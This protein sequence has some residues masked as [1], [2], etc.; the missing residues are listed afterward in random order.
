[1][2]ISVSPTGP[3]GLPFPR[4]AELLA[5]SATYQTAVGAANAAEAL[6][7]IQ[8]PYVDLENDGLALPSACITDE[9]GNA[10]EMNRLT[11]QS[12]TLGIE[13]WF[14]LPVGLTDKRDIVIDFRNTLGAILEE[15]LANAKNPNGSGGFYFG[16]VSWSK[17]DRGTP[18]IVQP[19]ELES[20]PGSATPE[21]FLYAAFLIEWR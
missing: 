20:D 4:L 11:E 5:A 9:D 18:R 17:H 1:M 7:T 19:V 15:M 10:Q 14:P 16:M 21:P 3:L 2:P 13:F 8:Y 6:E 12:G